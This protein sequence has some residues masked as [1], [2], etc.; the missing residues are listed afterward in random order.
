MRPIVGR[1]PRDE[2]TGLRK[3]L[4]RRRRR[5]RRRRRS[6]KVLLRLSFLLGHLSDPHVGPVLRPRWRELAGKRFTGYINWRRGRHLIHDMAML[7]RITAD[8]LAQKL[9]MWR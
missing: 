7:E 1:W 8:L 3:P 9:I 2:A 6:R 4:T 5:G